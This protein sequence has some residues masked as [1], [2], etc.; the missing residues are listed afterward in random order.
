MTNAQVNAPSTDTEG[1]LAPLIECSGLSHIAERPTGQPCLWSDLGIQSRVG[2]A[3]ESERRHIDRR[4]RPLS[5]P[6]EAEHNQPVRAYVGVTD[7]DWYRFLQTRAATEVNFWQPSGGRR[8]GAVPA[9][10]PFLFK[11]HYA[12]GNRL[13]GGGFLSGWASLPISR[14]WEFFGESN[15]CA[16]E[17]EMRARI[18][19][20]RARLDDE[21]GDPEIGCIMLRDVRFFTPDEAQDAP[22]GWSGNIVQGRSYDLSAGEGS[23]VEAVLSRLLRS[24][25]AVAGEAGSVPGDVFG[26][27]RLAPVRVGQKAFKALVQEAYG[28]RCAVTG[29]RIVPVLQAA[30]I[31]PVTAAG[32]NRV[33][34]GMLLRS[35]VHTLFDRGYLGVHPDRKTLMVS[36]RLRTTWGN[37][38]EFYQRAASG[39]PIC[40]PTRVI[41]R[42]HRDFLSWHADTMFAAS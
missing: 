24:R 2:G 10:A 25:D 41:D 21:H 11:T 6:G 37:G 20:Y 42:P 7:W 17:V 36:P 4:P 26:T 5:A 40:M 9:G 30:H 19:K 35:D 34:N 39:D 14:A 1:C 32:E 18:A 29:D 31:Q 23:Y 8:F 16:T 28:R 3:D 22:P 38:E 13:V 12:H 33:D 27:P 15:G